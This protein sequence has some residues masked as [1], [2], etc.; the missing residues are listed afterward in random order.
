M[1]SRNT[2]QQRMSIGWLAMAIVLLSMFVVQII[3][4]II[5]GNMELFQTDPGPQGVKA[6]AIMLCGY[7]L[8]PILLNTLESLWFR[9]VSTVVVIIYTLFMMLHQLNHH[10][11]GTSPGL[12]MAFLD[13]THHA[14]GVWTS[15]LSICWLRQA[16]PEKSSFNPVQ[17]QSF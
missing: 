1:K 13:F 3:E 15:Y 6:I 2:Y 12:T 7:A 17:L 8:M 16:S 14:I 10:L 5:H 11:T 9:W 4:C